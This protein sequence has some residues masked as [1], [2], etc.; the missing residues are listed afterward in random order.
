MSFQLWLTGHAWAAVLI[1]WALMGVAVC[2]AFSGLRQLE[3]VKRS[4]RARN[5]RR[6]ATEYMQLASRSDV[7][8]E[9]FT[10]MAAA[11]W[12]LRRAKEHGDDVPDEL[13]AMCEGVDGP[14]TN[15]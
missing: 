14:E 6:I 12:W 2:L 1:G 5:A 11:G 3:N 4:Q 10:Y 8:G 7:D 15:D 13:L 9:A